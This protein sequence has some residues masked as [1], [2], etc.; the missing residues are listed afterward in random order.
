MK[1]KPKMHDEEEYELDNINN[2]EEDDEYRS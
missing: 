2:E 1:R